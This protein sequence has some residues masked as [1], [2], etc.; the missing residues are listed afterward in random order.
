MVHKQAADITADMVS[1]VEEFG[2]LHDKVEQY[3]HHGLVPSTII[4]EGIEVHPGFTTIVNAA[5]R[6]Y[7]ESLDELLAKI[8]RV[9]GSPSPSERG[10]WTRRLETWTMKAVEDEGILGGAPE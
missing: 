3:L 5:Y 9:D 4:Q 1:G 6:V 10:W 7:L 8:E 2:L